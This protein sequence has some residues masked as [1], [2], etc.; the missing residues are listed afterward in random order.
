MKTLGERIREIR[1]DRKMTQQEFSEILSLSRPFISRIET[2]KEIPSQSTLKLIS[3]LFKVNFL[4]LVDESADKYDLPNDINV[5]LEWIHYKEAIDTLHFILTNI[6]IPF[7]SEKYYVK[8]IY[9]ILRQIK[10]VLNRE[11]NYLDFETLD[12]VY[13]Q[14]GEYIENALSAINTEDKNQLLEDE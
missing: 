4:W 6:H 13:S 12:N 5:K 2:N 8:Q 1:N 3:Q 7:S 14:I 9:D 11:D 10:W